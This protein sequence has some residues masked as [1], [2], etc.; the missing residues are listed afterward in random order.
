MVVFHSYSGTVF[1][2][3]NGSADC[4]HMAVI[5]SFWLR[6]DWKR[7][8]TRVLLC[9]QLCMCKSNITPRQ[10]PRR[11][12]ARVFVVSARMRRHCALWQE[13]Q[14]VGLS[15]LVSCVRAGPWLLLVPLK[16]V[17]PKCSSQPGHPHTVEPS[18]TTKV[19]SS[20]MAWHYHCWLGTQLT[21]GDALHVET[22]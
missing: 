13:V 3:M 21:F 18:E 7:M 2:H 14:A 17:P 19:P 12:R 22:S 15:V 5:P 6:G 8:G 10:N 1:R 11:R 4:W 20:H 9:V 16:D